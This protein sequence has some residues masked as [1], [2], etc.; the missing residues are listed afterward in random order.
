MSTCHAA[1]AVVRPILMAATVGTQTEE[2]R[3]RGE[4]D[5]YSTRALHV[6]SNGALA[7][8]GV[9]ESGAILGAA[10]NRVASAT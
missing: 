5:S 2:K 6:A 10:T 1:D 9:V 3:M 4:Y 7:V 8:G